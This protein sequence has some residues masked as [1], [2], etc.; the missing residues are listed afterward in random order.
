[1][2]RLEYARLVAISFAIELVLFLP[3]SLGG[4]DSSPVGPLFWTCHLP[5]LLLLSLIPGEWAERSGVSQILIFVLNWFFLAFL[6]VVL[7][8]WRHSKKSG[9]PPVVPR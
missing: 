8:R 3:L 5:A 7:V 6:L 1:M 4:V 2:T 9:M